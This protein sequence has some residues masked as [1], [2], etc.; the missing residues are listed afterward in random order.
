[1]APPYQNE[2]F[3]QWVENCLDGKPIL[4]AQYWLSPEWED[5]KPAT[6]SEKTKLM[7][8]IDELEAREIYSH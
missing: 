2:L 7:R 5:P 3:K 6:Q 4:Q 1:M 8:F